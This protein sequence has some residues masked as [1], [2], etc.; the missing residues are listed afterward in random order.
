MKT[1]SQIAVVNKVNIPVKAIE[2]YINTNINRSETRRRKKIQFNA[3]S[4]YFEN[5]DSCSAYVPVN[6]I[7]EISLA[8]EGTH[9][10]RSVN[11]NVST[12]YFFTC[13]KGKDEIYKVVWGT[14]L[15]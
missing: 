15:S 12:I 11:V 2:N 8:E 13:A 14:S 9:N 6:G 5:I 7:V 10:F 3:F 4:Y 1:S